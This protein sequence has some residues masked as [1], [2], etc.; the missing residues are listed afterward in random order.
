MGKS[1]PV[2]PSGL[3]LEGRPL[4]CPVNGPRAQLLMT[5]LTRTNRVNAPKHSGL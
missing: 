5:A 3:N 4:H 1:V 2:L